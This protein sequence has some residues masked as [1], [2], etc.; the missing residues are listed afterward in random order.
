MYLVKKRE[1]QEAVA[2]TER[3]GLVKT[4]PTHGDQELLALGRVNL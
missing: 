1:R 3:D 2:M 4:M